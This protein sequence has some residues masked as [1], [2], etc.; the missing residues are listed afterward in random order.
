MSDG[1]TEGN[2]DSEHSNAVETLTYPIPSVL[3]TTRANLA[4]KSSSELTLGS[5]SDGPHVLG[6]L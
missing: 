3:G 1:K 5:I 4:S 2:V 6:P